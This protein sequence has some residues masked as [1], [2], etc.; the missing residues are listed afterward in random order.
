MGEEEISYQV[1][2]EEN[3]PLQRFFTAQMGVLPL[4]FP[5]STQYLLKSESHFFS[6]KTRLRIR[7]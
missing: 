3:N 1:S 4:D 5:L 7:F 6:G 2:V